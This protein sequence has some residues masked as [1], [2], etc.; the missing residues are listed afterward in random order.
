[1]AASRIMKMLDGSHYGVKATA[2]EKRLMR[3]WIDVGAPYPGTYAA[4]GCG[5]IGGYFANRQINVDTHWPTTRAGAEVVSRRCKSCHNSKVDIL[6][7]TLVDER[8]I[9]FWRFELS[10]PRLK[11]SRHIVFNL[12]RPE[13]SLM[14]LAPLSKSSGGFGLC[15]DKKGKVVDVFKD[16]SDP[17]YKKLLAMIAAGKDNL[18]TI[19]RFDMPG[20]RPLPQYVREMRRYGILPA[21]HRDNDPVDPYELD[22]RYWKSLWYRPPVSTETSMS[23]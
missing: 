6:P 1:S 3:L 4:L 12:S 16:R 17:D 7:S 13:K 21:D 22:R 2:E 10:D 18:Q 20:F 15:R 23:D 5:S 8:G 9:S 19:K 14:L 11:L